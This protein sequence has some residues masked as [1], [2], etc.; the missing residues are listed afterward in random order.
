MKNNKNIFF[1]A[2]ENL[3]SPLQP[4]KIPVTKTSHLG[5]G[6]LPPRRENQKYLQ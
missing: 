3:N 5:H 4:A 1:R 2:A 6:V